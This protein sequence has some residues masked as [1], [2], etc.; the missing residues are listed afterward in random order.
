MKRTATGLGVAAAVACAVTLGAQTSTTTASQRTSTTDKSHDVTVTGCLARDSS[1]GFMLNNARM[2]NGASSSTTTTSGTTT[3]GTTGAAGGGATTSGTNA[4]ASMSNAPA[5]SWMLS[6]GNDLDKHV[7]H[8]IQ[9]TG[10]TT[11][12]PAM[13]HTS[14]ASAAGAGTTAAS[15]DPTTTAGGATGTTAGAAGTTGTRDEQRKGDA[16]GMQPHLDV[17]SVK[18]ISTSCS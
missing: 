12:D 7:G 16:H 14:T 5:M 17:Q 13:N 11:W 4:S 3:T 2:D 15:P 1:N 9:V 10:K 8:K 18:M 6:G